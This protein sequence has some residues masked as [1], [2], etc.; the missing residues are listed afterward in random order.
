MQ[1]VDRD[2]RL[3]ALQ[4]DNGQYQCFGRTVANDRHQ[5]TDK[6]V[7]VLVLVPRQCPMQVGVQQRHLETFVTQSLPNRVQ[8]TSHRIDNH[9]ALF[10][11]EQVALACLRRQGKLLAVMDSSLA[12]VD[13]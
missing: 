9:L 3:D 1:R 2:L 13:G 7:H 5:P 8:R 10:V 6:G 4:L 11:S 12:V